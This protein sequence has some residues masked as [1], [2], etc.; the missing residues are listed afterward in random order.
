MQTD[1]IIV[2]GG[3]KYEQ[4][5]LT[6][7]GKQKQL[8]VDIKE[9]DTP[10]Q[11]ENFTVQITGLLPALI[12][13]DTKYPLPQLIKG[14]PETYALML[15]CVTTIRDAAIHG[16]CT[17][18]LS[19]LIQST[20]AADPFACGGQITVLDLAFHPIRFCL[21]QPYKNTL[22]A[23]QWQNSSSSPSADSSSS[24]DWDYT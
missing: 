11:I 13:L 1:R 20:K 17:E 7:V 24:N 12:Y 9:A 14:N 10:L 15:E 2:Y 6:L 22:E 21:P 18:A 19:T 5:L 16:Q 23:I 8:R 4:Q 3:H